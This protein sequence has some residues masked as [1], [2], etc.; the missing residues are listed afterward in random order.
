MNFDIQDFTT[1]D[2]DKVA[3]L[4][5]QLWDGSSD[6][7]P[8]ELDSIYHQYVLR[9]YYVPSSHFNLVAM[10]GGEICACLLAAPAYDLKN[11]LADEWI[12]DR[13]HGTDAKKY[14]QELK[15]Y[16]D[17]MSETEHSHAKE[18]EA[19][20]LFFGSIRKG[21]GK[22]L[23]DEFE[24]RC[25]E[26]SINS[27]LLWTDEMCNYDYYYQKGFEEVAKAPSSAMVDG[28]N[29]M[30]WIFRKNF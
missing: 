26:H 8:E 12:K 19:V 14:F 27:M 5:A 13:L 22:T 28:K 30:T 3:E 25:K 9:Y 29:V 18:N 23:M 11:N 2:F 17:S 15:T 21:A 20:L 24:K 1:N 10:Q 4:I 16:L 6:E 7:I